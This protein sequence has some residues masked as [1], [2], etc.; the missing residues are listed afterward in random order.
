MLVTLPRLTDLRVI[1]QTTYFRDIQHT[2][3]ANRSQLVCYK[4]ITFSECSRKQTASLTASVVQ[5]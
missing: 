2:H 3:G 4:V 5:W 1:L